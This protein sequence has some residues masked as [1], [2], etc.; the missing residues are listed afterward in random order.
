MSFS[1]AMDTYEGK[2]LLYPETGTHVSHAFVQYYMSFHSQP[3]FS[4]LKRLD[5]STRFFMQTAVL[6]ISIVLLILC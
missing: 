6:C 2:F 3:W 4:I 5:Y 1:L